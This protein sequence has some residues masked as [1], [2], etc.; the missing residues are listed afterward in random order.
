MRGHIV[1]C[2][3]ADGLPLM[4]AAADGLDLWSTGFFV[5]QDGAGAPLGPFSF[6]RWHSAF[7]DAMHW[8]YE[9]SNPPPR[10]W[11]HASGAEFQSITLEASS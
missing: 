1:I 4:W 10:G 7:T 11:R 5:D 8:A 3:P 2:W 6:H 9:P